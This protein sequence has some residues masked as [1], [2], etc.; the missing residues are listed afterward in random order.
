MCKTSR[1]KPFPQEQDCTCRK[2]K[3]RQ[4]TNHTQLARTSTMAHQHTL[5]N[6]NNVQNF[7]DPCERES[8]A[9]LWRGTCCALASLPQFAERRDA[10]FAE[11]PKRQEDKREREWRRGRKGRNRHREE[12]VSGD[13]IFLRDDMFL[14]VTW[15]FEAKSQN[16]YMKRYIV[17]L[18]PL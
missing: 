7:R 4:K 2:Q 15:A 12:P 5:C 14:S 16:M 9:R 18:H 13:Y 3:R 6:P 10:S 17:M 11:P 8:P 1:G